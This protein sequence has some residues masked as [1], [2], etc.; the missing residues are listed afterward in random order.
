MDFQVNAG[1]A[2]IRV[3]HVVIYCRTGPSVPF[4]STIFTVIGEYN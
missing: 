3:I 1:F 2:F 4:L